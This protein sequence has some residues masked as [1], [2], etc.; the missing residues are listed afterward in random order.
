[1]NTF[2]NPNAGDGV[3]VID[4]IRAS[5]ESKQAQI[6]DLAAL[7]ARNADVAPAALARLQ[8]VA[9]AGENVFAELMETVKVCSLGQISESLFAVGGQYRRSM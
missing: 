4:M 7:H 1:V 2:L 3:V 8:E 9:L 6:D 5:D